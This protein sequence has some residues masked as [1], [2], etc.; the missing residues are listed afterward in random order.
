V[1]VKQ[2]DILGVLESANATTQVYHGDS[3]S[4]DFDLLFGGFLSPLLES[5]AP[6][7]QSLTPATHQLLLDSSRT[8]LSFRYFLVSKFIILSEPKNGHKSILSIL[9]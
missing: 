6:I 3:M 8:V 1:R 9:P 2:F 4:R 7:V 5:L